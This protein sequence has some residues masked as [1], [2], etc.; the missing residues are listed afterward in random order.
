MEIADESNVGAEGAVEEVEKERVE[1]GGEGLRKV[2][3]VT[4]AT[5]GIGFETAQALYLRGFHV[6]L[7]TLPPPNSFCLLYFICINLFLFIVVIY[8]LIF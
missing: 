1:P 2:A 6:V 8:I 5:S 7:G 4:G 3:A